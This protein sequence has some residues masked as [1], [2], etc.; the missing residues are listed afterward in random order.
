MEDLIQDIPYAACTPR[1]RPSFFFVAL[2]L[3]ALGT[4][5]TTI[6]FTVI[7]GVLLKPLPFAEPDRLVVVHSHS[8]NWNTKAFGQ[9]NLTYPD[10]LDCQ[11]ESHTLNLE[12][13]RASC[14]ERV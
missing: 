2:L 5:A 8:N 3:L 9:Q 1:Q 14:R 6:M 11:R 12:I 7:N 4:G 10:F 13:G